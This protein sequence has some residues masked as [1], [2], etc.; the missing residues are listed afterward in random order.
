MRA[1]MPRQRRSPVSTSYEPPE[2]D[3]RED[4][5]AEDEPERAEGPPLRD[6]ALLVLVRQP[7]S[8]V[9]VHLLYG[10]RRACLEESSVRALCEC[11]QLR[12]RGRDGVLFGVLGAGKLLVDHPVRRA[13]GDRRNGQIGRAS[14][15]E[16]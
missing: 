4:G 6:L 3:A 9:L 15:R 14:G 11:A 7:R 5:A 1:A 2:P 13:E 10:R 12:R 8:E 16:T